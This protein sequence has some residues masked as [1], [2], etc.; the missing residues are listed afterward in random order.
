MRSLRPLLLVLLAASST[1]GA[2]DAPSCCR[3]LELR[4]YDMQ[5]GGR[6]VLVGMF[7]DVFQDA[8]DAMGMTIAGTFRDEARPDRFVWLRGFTDVESRGRQLDAFYTGPVW[9][10]HRDRARATMLDASNVLLLR[11]AGEGTG[12]ALPPGAPE[13]EPR[14]IVA[15]VHSFPGPVPADFPAWFHRA[16][17]PLLAQSGAAVVGQFVTETAPNSYPRLAIREGENVFVWFAAHADL[18]AASRPL[19]AIAGWDA[20]VAPRLRE[21]TKGAADRIVL[22]PTRRSRLR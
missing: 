8:Q 6:D 7:E 5:P 1:A 10:Q 14:V 20:R 21:V 12:L 13:G 11:P 3:V 2:A 17:V 4:Q 9:K 16:A 18:A 19:E 15:T 22:R